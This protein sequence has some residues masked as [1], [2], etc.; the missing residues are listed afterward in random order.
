MNKRV[1]IL[2]IPLVATLL[3]S[4]C[5]ALPAMQDLIGSVTPETT[6]ESEPSE[7]SSVR[8]R[9]SQRMRVAPGSYLPSL[10]TPA[11][12]AG[13]S[14]IDTTAKHVHNSTLNL[15]VLSERVGSSHHRSVFFLGWTEAL[16]AEPTQP[17]KPMEPPNT[18]PQTPGENKDHNY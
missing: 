6:A 17:G 11:P 13:I 5:S 16:L 4:A 7:R 1:F 9:E 18:F 8:S 2:L 14:S 15:I 10:P 12:T 3:V